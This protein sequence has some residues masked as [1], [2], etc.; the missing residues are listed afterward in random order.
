MYTLSKNLAKDLCRFIDK[1]PTPFHAVSELSVSLSAVDFETLSE[2]DEWNLVA[3]GRYLV[4]RNGSAIAAF[5]VGTE[6]LSVS[7][8]KIIG[9][10]T[11][12]PNLQ[13]K[14]NAGFD[15]AGYAQLAV[16]PYGGLLLASW[17]NRDLSIAG[18]VVVRS[19]NGELVSKLLKIDRPLL[20]LPQLA[21]HLD[22]EVN[23]KGVVLNKQTH[24]SPIFALTGVGSGE[25]GERLKELLRTTVGLTDDQKIIG[26]DLALFNIEPSTIGGLNDEF[27]YAPRLDNL[28]SCHIAMLALMEVANPI[29]TCVVVLYDNEEVGSQSAQ[30]ALSPFLKD[31]LERLAGNN[32]KKAMSRSFC[33]S[34]DMAHA[35]HPNYTEKHEPKHSPVIGGGPVIKTNVNQ[36]YAST[37][38]STAFFA[39]LCKRAEVPYQNFV[40]RSDLACG[41]TIGP[42]TAAE[43]GICTVDVGSPMLSMHSIR[44]QA[45]VEDHFAMFQVLRV[46][47]E[48]ESVIPQM[49]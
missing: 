23:D 14:P 38:L 24:T 41:T 42:L 32:L 6:S 15:K 19:G 22:R 26:T 21:I 8:F 18:R 49:S 43:L 10:H 25:A 5:V 9:A 35:V 27:I 29:S 30:G 4:T 34:A 46:F 37:G 39:D 2:G 20:S 33:I 12:S 45:G 7:G 44:E 1:S 31:I 36:R 13:L 3:G 17:L 48:N 28:A 40:S 16:E 11:D 47:F